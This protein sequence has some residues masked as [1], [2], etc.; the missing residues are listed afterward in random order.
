M[1]KKWTGERLETFIQSRD[2]IDH[3]H[4]YAMVA[5]YANDKVVLDIASGEGYGT[6][7]ISK[8]AK[9]VYGV[10]IDENSVLDAQK[11]YN[12]DNL[13]FRIGSAD[14]IPLE[15]H[16]VDVVVSFET[17][18]HHDKHE[19]MMME[20]KRVLKPDGIVI[21]STPDKYQYTDKQNFHNEFHVKELYKNEFVELLN[22]YFKKNVLYNQIFSNGNSLVVEEEH[23][24][25]F[26][27]YSGNFTEVSEIEKEAMYL[28]M[29]SSD[30]DFDYKPI[31]VFEGTQI[32]KAFNDG[33]VKEI[34]NSITFKLGH[35]ILLPFKFFKRIK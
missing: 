17:I 7:L 3:L 25:K 32:I 12:H 19:E 14:K 13:E 4:R 6:N 35:Y 2:T 20:V 5:H 24:N 29:I 34:K 27:L 33:F 18:E 26:E 21:I 16:S 1:K 9:Y 10:D 22:R 11:K 8:S 23:F 31:L 15:D 28:I 30:K